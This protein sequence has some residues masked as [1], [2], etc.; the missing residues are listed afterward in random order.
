[1]FFY[2]CWGTHYTKR[3]DRHCSPPSHRLFPHLLFSGLLCFAFALAHQLELETN[4]DQLGST[5]IECLIRAWFSF[6]L[7][8]ELFRSLCVLL[9]LAHTAVVA[10]CIIVTPIVDLFRVKDRGNFPGFIGTSHN[11]PGLH[12]S[13]PQSFKG[14]LFAFLFSLSSIMP[15]D[16]VAWFFALRTEATTSSN[17][18]AGSSL[19]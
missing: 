7:V 11:L 3:S 19:D 14:K 2:F 1:M 6:L 18:R 15:F 5:G 10:I 13:T 8:S 12:S 4:W 16:W 17:R 9:R